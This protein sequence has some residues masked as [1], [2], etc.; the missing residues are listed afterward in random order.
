MADIQVAASEEDESSSDMEQI[1]RRIRAWKCSGWDPI[2]VEAVTAGAFVLA[3]TELDADNDQE[4]ILECAR[5][6]VLSCDGVMR[7]KIGFVN[8]GE[9]SYVRYPVITRQPHSSTD[10]RRLRRRHME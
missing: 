8:K 5:G 4:R 2:T 6:I 10:Q 1:V 7:C 9:S 3:G